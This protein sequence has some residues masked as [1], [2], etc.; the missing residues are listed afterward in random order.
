M[1]INETEVALVGHP[2]APIGMGEH[3]RCTFRALRSV[4]LCPGIDDIYSLNQ[5]EEEARREF[6]PYLIKE[7]R[8]FGIFHINGDEVE[9]ALATIAHRPGPHSAYRI[10]YPA[11]ELARYPAVWARQLER[12]DEVWAPSRFVEAA[13]RESVAR[14][15]LHM[16]LA[17]QVSIAR[18]LGRRWF[19]IPE[20]SYAFLFFFDLRSYVKRK[21]PSAVVEAFRRAVHKRPFADCSLVLKMHGAEADGEGWRSLRDS[22]REFG[23]RVVLVDRTLT[24]NETKNLI[25]CCDAFVSLHRSE[26]FGRGLSEAMYLGKPVIGTGYSGNLDFMSG[27]SSLLVDHRLVAIGD[28]EYPHAEGQVWAEPDVDQ[29][30]SYM[31]RLIDD[32]EYGRQLGRKASLHIRQGFSYRAAGVRYASRLSEIAGLQAGSNMGIAA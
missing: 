25:R 13:L 27:D 24:D 16:P 5:P 15:V 29:A 28:G 1:Q 2:F 4:G 20:S 17:C 6:A 19:N 14:P 23:S 21:N 9:Q 22:L 18:F 7:G 12:F 10:V 31:V 11:W 8:R 26:G 3:V 30:A 32:P